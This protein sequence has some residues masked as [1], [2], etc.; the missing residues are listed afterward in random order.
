MN[1]L[2]WHFPLIRPKRQDSLKDLI[3]KVRSEL[4]E[5]EKAPTVHEQLLEAVDVLHSAETL[6]RKLFNQHSGDKNLQHLKGYA[7]DLYRRTVI[8]KNKLQGYYE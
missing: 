2:R 1:V 7:Y 5:L 3:T 4:D 8:R 6:V